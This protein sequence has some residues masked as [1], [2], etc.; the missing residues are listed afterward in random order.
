MFTHTHDEKLG[1]EFGSKLITIPEE[2]KVVK[3]Q[4]TFRVSHTRG[5]GAAHEP[6]M[7]LTHPFAL[8]AGTRRELNPSVPSRVPTTA[9][10]R[11]AFSS[12]T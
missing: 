7:T 6:I 10:L 3:L 9:V 8:Q 1:V 2:D 12:T 5:A 11:V 4:C